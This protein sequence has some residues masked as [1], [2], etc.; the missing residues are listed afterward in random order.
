MP[1]GYHV[2]DLLANANSV[3]HR[4]NSYRRD[5]MGRVMNVSTL[6]AKMR[7]EWTALIARSEFASGSG[8]VTLGI[9]GESLK[10]SWAGGAVSASTSAGKAASHVTQERF[11]QML[12][13]YRSVT[14]LASDPDV[15][16]KSSDIRPLDVLF[17]P[18]NAFL[19]ESDRF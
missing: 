14:A 4:G 7:A 19:F 9:G 6:A 3:C 11:V 18:R 17:P 12:H 13:G 8:A 5:C 1:P 16:L 10:I 15:K 2:T